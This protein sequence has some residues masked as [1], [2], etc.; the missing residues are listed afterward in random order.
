M[1]TEKALASSGGASPGVRRHGHETLPHLL[2]APRTKKPS[3][4]L[5]KVPAT[6]RRQ[7]GQPPPRGT[8]V[9]PCNTPREQP[10]THPFEEA[11]STV[12]QA[13]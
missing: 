8:L 9:H 12:A 5:R 10:P 6:F 7:L 13:N 2:A 3:W 1:P 4:T 11:D